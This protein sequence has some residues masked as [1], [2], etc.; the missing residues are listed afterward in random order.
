MDRIPFDPEKR[1]QEEQSHWDHWKRKEDKK[2]RILAEKAALQIEVAVNLKHHRFLLV[3]LIFRVFQD[4]LRTQRER[5]AAVEEDRRNQ[6]KLQSEQKKK[7][8]EI[9]PVF[10][11]ARYDEM[12]KEENVN[13][14]A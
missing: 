11:A 6:E 13:I 2:E 3:F 8:L 1:R 10:L 12:E 4:W 5:Q 7:N 9:W 14:F